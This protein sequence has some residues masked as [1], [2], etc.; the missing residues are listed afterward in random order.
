MIVEKERSGPRLYL[1]VELAGLTDRLDGRVRGTEKSTVN[2][3]PMGYVLPLTEVGKT[4]SGTGFF[5]GERARIH[6][7]LDLVQ[8]T[9]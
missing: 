2:P 8:D 4:G 1:E 7:E 6:V 3:K 9:C 5:L